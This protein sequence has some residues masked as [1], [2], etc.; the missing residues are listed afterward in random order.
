MFTYIV[1]Y[2]FSGSLAF[3]TTFSRKYNRLI[4]FALFCFLFVFAGFRDIYVDRDY[5]TYVR[6][7]Q[8]L[9]GENIEYTKI[10][11]IL[12]VE[13]A[14]FF[15]P[16]FSSIFWGS[17]YYLGMFAIF[18]FLGVW[19]KL[20]S[21]YLSNS[22]FLSV[23]LYV[24][25]YFFLHEMTQI[26]TGVAAGIVLLGFRYIYERRFFLYLLHIVAACTFHYSSI[27]FIPIYF[28]NTKTLNKTIWY[29]II[30][31]TMMLVITRVDA[32]HILENYF[33]FI[34]KVKVYLIATKEK[35]SAAPK[36]IISKEW[37]ISLMLTIA[38]LYKS[39]ILKEKNKYFILLLKVN[40]ISILSLVLFSS[41]PVFA[42]RIYELFGIVQIV[43]YPCAIFLFREKHI[44]YLIVALISMRNFCNMIYDEAILNPYKSWW[45]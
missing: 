34:D 20:K 12:F 35:A 28:L 13:P 18:A 31:I 39:E 29:S 44:G 16:Y 15:I 43:L 10:E 5:S 37:L 7:V 4:L 21:F 17:N 42:N 41:I 2:I 24:S 3:L 19:A 38:F 30:A 25:G 33:G 36:Y 11:N 9:L 27:L 45:F 32:V 23:L 26:R 22:T 8:K 6:N 1:T 14:Y 40:I